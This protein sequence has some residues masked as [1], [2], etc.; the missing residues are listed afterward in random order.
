MTHVTSPPPR[1]PALQCTQEVPPELLRCGRRGLCR[2]EWRPAAA[3]DVGGE[4][5]EAPL[6]GTETWRKTLGKSWEN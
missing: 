2:A 3:P 4:G 5:R 6:S 1:A